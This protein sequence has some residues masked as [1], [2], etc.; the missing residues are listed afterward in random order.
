[1][2]HYVLVSI[3]VSTFIENSFLYVAALLV[4]LEAACPELTAVHNKQST[5]NSTEDGSGCRVRQSARSSFKKSV[6]GPQPRAVC[7]H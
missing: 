4:V 1:M 5:A 6:T 3:A 2:C 7:S